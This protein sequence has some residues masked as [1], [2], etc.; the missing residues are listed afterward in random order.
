MEVHLKVGFVQFLL[1][2]ANQHVQMAIHLW[3]EIAPFLLPVHLQL[4]TQL[5]LRVLL[6]QAS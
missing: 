4:P 5:Q 1:V 2:K 3:E 6:H